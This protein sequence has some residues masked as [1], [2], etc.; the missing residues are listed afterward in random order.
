MLYNL[1]FLQNLRYVI[2]EGHSVNFKN[3][4]SE[5][6]LKSKGWLVDTLKELDLDLGLV[7]LCG[8]WMGSLAA[9]MF[10]SDLKI[11]KIRSFDIDHSCTLGAEALNR[12]W[13]YDNW[14]FKASTLDI[15]EM[16]YPT[17]Y[18][19]LDDKGNVHSLIELADTLINT[20][21]EHIDDFNLWYNNIPL[22]M[23]LVV[24]SNN[25]YEHEEHINCVSSLE[26]FAEQTPMSIVLYA[27]ELKLKNYTRFMRIG[28]K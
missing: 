5:G 1:K 22:G 26:E 19:T 10:E 18:L 27:G 3:V 14:R 23:C 12:S 21:C 16:D 25:N 11:D 28:Y 4:F 13:L 9:F 20:S 8:G 7:F 2:D 15:H 24:Q 6:Q 17:K